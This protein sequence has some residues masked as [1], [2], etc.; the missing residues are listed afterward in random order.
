MFI[1]VSCTC[2]AIMS[3]AVIMIQGRDGANKKQ[4]VCIKLSQ[5]PPLEDFMLQKFFKYNIDNSSDGYGNGR[6]NSFVTLL[7]A[8]RTK[9]F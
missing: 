6:G 4:G 3:T 7:V 9:I 2:Y 1:R 8:W 5:L